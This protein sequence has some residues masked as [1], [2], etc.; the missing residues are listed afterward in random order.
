MMIIRR[1]DS[2][3]DSSLYTEGVLCKSHKHRPLTWLRPEAQHFFGEA[4][5][6][7]LMRNPYAPV[8]SAVS[9]GP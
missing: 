5:T 2:Q 8:C 7:A 6:F 1:L 4:T 3:P 9:R